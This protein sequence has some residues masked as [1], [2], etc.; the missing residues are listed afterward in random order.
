MPM[1]NLSGV[2]AFI[3][4]RFVVGLHLLWPHLEHGG[5][6]ICDGDKTVL[7]DCL[8]QPVHPHMMCVYFRVP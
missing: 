6:L 7:V 8:A 3:F 2:S 5:A 4:V 1:L